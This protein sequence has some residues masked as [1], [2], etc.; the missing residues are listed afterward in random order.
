[1]NPIELSSKIEE[2]YRRYLKT[3]FYFKDPDLRN[4][5]EQALDLGHLSKGPYLEGTP[6]FKPGQTPREL[7]RDLLGFDIGP[8]IR[9][10]KGSFLSLTR[11]ASLLSKRI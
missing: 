1:M 6:V 3:T 7:F 9:L 5:F 8:K 2:A 4:S 11:T 10:P